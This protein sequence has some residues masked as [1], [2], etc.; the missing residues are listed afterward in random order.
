MRILFLH[1]NFPAQFRHLATVLGKDPSNQVV[2]G[3]MNAKGNIPGVHKVL[4]QPSREVHPH[5]HHYLRNHESAVLQGQ[6]VY[7]LAQDLKSAGF[8]PDI[9]YGHSGWGATMFIKDVFPQSTATLLL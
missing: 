7:R 4:Y 6:A 8:Y 2:F 9:V 3:T 1:P 5:T